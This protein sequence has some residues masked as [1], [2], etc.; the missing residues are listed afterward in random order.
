MLQKIKG[1]YHWV[2]AA[3]ALLQTMIFG[4]AVNNFSSYHMIP[5]TEALGISRT[6]FSLAVS[7][8]AVMGVICTYLS[9]K[10]IQKFGY[11][12]ATASALASAAVAYVL[13]ATMRAY[14]MLVVGCVL[15]GFAHGMCLMAGVSRLLNGWFYK[16][17]GT[18]L[19]VVSAASGLGTTVMGFI[20]ASAIETVSWRLSFAEVAGLQFFLA[21]LVFALVRDVPEKIGLRPFGEGDA[22]AAKKKASKYAWDGFFM[23]VLRK[24]PAYYLMCVCAFCSGLC[25]LATQYIIVPFLQDCGMSVTRTSRIYG[26][27]MFVLTFVKLFMGVLCDTI[28][29]KRVILL[30]HI[31]CAASLTMIVTL[32]QTDAAMV[33]ALI[34]YDLGLPITTMMFPLLSA[35]LFGNR[36]QNQYIGTIMAMTTAGNIISEPLGNAVFDW[37]GSYRPVFW[38]AAVLALAMIPVYC[39]LFGMVFRDRKRLHPES[40]G[41][42]SLKNR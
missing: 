6:A 13:F 9:G 10:L 5:V 21:V 39:L 33:G 42:A 28:G 16:Y 24:R 30:C 27:M 11:R 8:R 34:V 7:V 3:V 15:M 31:A 40:C 4:G 36:S 25:I 29:G 41:G 17:R 19:G 35:E 20:Q 38:G 23:D 32:P 2:I 26:I 14:W 37:T 22:I 12:K 1:H 18:V